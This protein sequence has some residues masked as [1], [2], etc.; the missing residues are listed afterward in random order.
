MP[1]LFF[2]TKITPYFKRQCK[3]MKWRKVFLSKM[4]YFLRK[5]IENVRFIILSLF[6]FI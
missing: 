5:N 2:L 4:S 1:L 3:Y 6:D